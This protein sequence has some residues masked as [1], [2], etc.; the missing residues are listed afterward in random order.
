MGYAGQ[1]AKFSQPQK[2]VVI[3]YYLAH[4][5]YIAATMRALGYPGRGTLIAWIHAAIPEARLVVVGNVSQR[6]YS[7]ALKQAGVM[8]LSTRQESAFASKVQVAA[9]R[10][11]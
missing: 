9:G 11:C 7:K 3:E 2:A 5:H 6:R 4:D 1:E 10:R 8:P